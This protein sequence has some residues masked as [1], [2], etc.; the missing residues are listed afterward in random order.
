V[1]DKG[2]SAG[3]LIQFTGGNAGT[4]THFDILG[5]SIPTSKLE[6]FNSSTAGGAAIDLEGS[7]VP[8]TDGG[9]LNFNDFSS[10]GSATIVAHAATAA[11]GGISTLSF[12]DNSTAGT[13]T[14]TG[15]GGATRN[16]SGALLVFHETSKAGTSLITVNGSQ[17]AGAFHSVLFF[18]GAASA[19]HA[20]LTANSGVDDGGEIAFMGSSPSSSAQIHLLGKGNLDVSGITLSSVTIGSLEGDGLVFLGAKILSVGNTSSD[21]VFSGVVQDGG[22]G[23]GSGGALT[24]LGTGT[25][26]LRGAN[27]YTGLTT[28]S[29]GSLV[30]ANRSGS[31]TGTGAVKVNA[32]RI[33]GNGTIAGALTIGT[34][35]GTGAA[36]V[37]RLVSGHDIVFTVNGALA[38]NSD[39]TYNDS[40][41]SVQ[42][43]ADNVT[44]NGVTI[45]GARLLIKDRRTTTLAVGTV[46]TLINNTAA[47]PI[48]G[49]F[50]NLADGVRVTIGSNKFQANYEGGDGNDLTLTVVP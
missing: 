1:A 9:I 12:F 27:S 17:T 41:S 33:G 40:F 15:E 38:F 26:T 11:Q 42:N 2:S 39:A 37:P 32:G 48:A 18:D 46:F 4:L 19:D 22:I 10:A 21:T 7:S 3:G 44:A 31:G 34:G 29:A 20:T 43:T 5:A 13:G 28:V 6:F 50:A 35:A 8:N 30:I 14:I 36:L 47:T 25:L 23:G 16:A 24:K 49:T 45:N